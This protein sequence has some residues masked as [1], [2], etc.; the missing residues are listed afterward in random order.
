MLAA[1]PVQSPTVLV[2]FASTASMPEKIIVGTVKKLPPP[3]TELSVPAIIATKKS[4]TNCEDIM[5][6]ES[7]HYS[8]ACNTFIASRSACCRISETAVV[9]HNCPL[10]KEQSV[11]NHDELHPSA[12]TNAPFI[13]VSI[14]IHRM[15]GRISPCSS[16]LTMSG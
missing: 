6:R 13:V 16:K 10:R 14:P 5:G 11:H 2:V 15:P 9:S 7:F 8:L 12:F 3:A 4:V 1:V